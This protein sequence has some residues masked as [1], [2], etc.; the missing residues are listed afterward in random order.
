M[1]FQEALDYYGT[2]NALCD[3]LGVD[4]SRGSQIKS[5]GGLSY[6][7][8]CVLEKDSGGKLVARREDDPNY[9]LPTPDRSTEKT[10][11]KKAKTPRNPIEKAA[12]I[13]G[14]QLALAEALNVSPQAVQQWVATGQAPPR[15]VI[16]IEQAT[17]GEVSR[18]EL[19]PDIYPE[20][21]AA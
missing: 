10:E 12:L 1:T 15:R 9:R 13:V 17:N 19:R 5:K 4:K 2:N 11:K 8:Q 7:M 18:H 16:A 20:D 21:H 14:S 3:A 6:P